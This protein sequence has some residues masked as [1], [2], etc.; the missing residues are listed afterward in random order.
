MTRTKIVREK[1]WERLRP[2]ARPDSRFHL[3]FSE[4]IPDFEGS[5]AATDRVVSLPVYKKA[6]FAFVTPDNGLALLRQRMLEAGK[7]LVVSTYGIYRGFYLLEPSMVPKGQERF[8]SWLDGLEYF[9]RPI[10]LAEISSRGRFD[11][12]VTGASAVSLDGV[13]FGKGH[14]FFDME[15]GM[16]TEVGLADEATPVV[17]VVHDVQVIEEKLFPSET[18][19]LVD[20]IAT[21][22]RLIEVKRQ[23]RPRG[24]KWHLLEPEVIAL[25]PPLQEL[26]KLRGIAPPASAPPA[27]GSVR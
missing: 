9:G 18:D 6:R 8:A 19:I 11:L 27:K 7:S 21:P 17:A 24:I 20:T 15:W 10:T 25:T 22:T 26:Q 4:V 16:F 5:E 2:V 1:I 13:R 14:G 23:Q 12:M 3:N